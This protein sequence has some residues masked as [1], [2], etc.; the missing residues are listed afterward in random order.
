M[1]T[2]KA[3]STILYEYHLDQV[4]ILGRKDGRIE[5]VTYGISAEDA[6]MA[7]IDAEKL[8]QVIAAAPT[9]I[10]EAVAAASLVR[11][12]MLKEATI[13]EPLKEVLYYV[14]NGKGVMV[15][16]ARDLLERLELL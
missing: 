2:V 14:L 4:I 1:L 9:S 10:A 11:P 7:A 3:A 8:R 16:K 15:D 13:L 12:E 6:G 5:T